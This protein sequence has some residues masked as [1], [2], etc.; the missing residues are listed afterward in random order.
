MSSA[1]LNFQDCRRKVIFVVTRLI[2]GGAQETA[3]ATARHFADKGWGVLLVTGPES[4]RE[5][6]LTTNVPIVVVPL[7]G[8]SL[9]LKG[10]LGSLWLLYRLFRKQKPDLVHSR[11]AKAR[12]LT[13]F[14]ARLA[15]VKIIVQTIHGFSFNNEVTGNRQLFIFLERLIARF[16]AR[17]ILVSEA[18]LDEGLALGILRPKTSQIIRSGVDVRRI[19]NVRHEATVELRERY[20][21]QG[22]PIVMSL[23]RLSSPKSPE[24]FVR[25][26]GI[27]LETHSDLRF[28]IVGDGP[29]RE[30]LM[31]LI[32]TLGIQDR[33][34][35]LGLRDD[36]PEILAASDIVVHSSTHEG[37]PKTVLEAM[38]AGKPIVATRVGG[39]PFLIEDMINGLLVDANDPP[40]LALAIR[41]LLDD[42]ALGER[43]ASNAK[44]VL[45]AFSLERTLLDTEALYD[46]LLEESTKKRRRTGLK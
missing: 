3:V 6:R 10:D 14:A 15:G 2:V 39:V 25:A 32:Q 44:Q 23:G 16:Y 17:N 45:P 30:D 27:L 38:A 12:F 43:L 24:I 21:P 35:L 20:S 36:V 11:T 34:S 31:A 5:G 18:D 42:P 19:Q 26:A 37:L 7:L 4:G 1:D 33:F 8:R 13:P 29:K 9:S 41:K 40:Q 46:Q 22:E 28:L